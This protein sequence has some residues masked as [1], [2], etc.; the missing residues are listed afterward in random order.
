M[1]GSLFFGFRFFFNPFIYINIQVSASQFLT[2]P[3]SP[4]H[5]GDVN[6]DVDEEQH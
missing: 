2:L 5:N 1:S 4:H 6:L 3:G